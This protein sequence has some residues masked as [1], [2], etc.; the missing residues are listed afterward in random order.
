MSQD[1]YLYNK[2]DVLK[3]LANIRDIDLLAE[4]EADYTSFRL[5]E[6]AIEDYVGQEVRILTFLRL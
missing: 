2:S 6:L 1:P 4:M 3:N 5:S